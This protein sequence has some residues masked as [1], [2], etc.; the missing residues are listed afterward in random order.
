MRNNPTIKRLADKLHRRA[1]LLKSAVNSGTYTAPETIYRLSHLTLGSKTLH[2]QGESGGYLISPPFESG[3]TL[4]VL[5]DAGTDCQITGNHTDH[6]TVQDTASGA[7]VYLDLIEGVLYLDA[8]YKSTLDFAVT[9]DGLR[10]IGQNGSMIGTVEESPFADSPWNRYYGMLTG[11]GYIWLNTLPVLKRCLLT[12]RG[13]GNFPFYFPQTDVVGL[14]NTNG[15]YHLVIDKPHNWYLQIAV[16]SGI[17]A[18]LAVLAL[19]GIW[20]LRGLRLI[21]RTDRSQLAADPEKLFFV[22]MF[23]GLCGFM[24]CGL[25]ND[26]SV[27]VNPVFWLC[28]GAMYARTAAHQKDGDAA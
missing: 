15:T 6:I 14:S 4:T 22:C 18:L 11:R 17:P 24:V 21:V 13:A 16:T 23:A 8:G 12:G 25:V 9:T 2:V 20:V 7:A 19:F 1:N 27:T 5:P 10:L 28:F 26:S 3:E